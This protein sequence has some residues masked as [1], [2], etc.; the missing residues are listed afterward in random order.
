M[1]IEKTINFTSSPTIAIKNI[2]D[3]I[4]KLKTTGVSD[5]LVYPEIYDLRSY[6]NIINIKPTFIELSTAMKLKGRI[7]SVKGNLLVL[8]TKKDYV[9]INAKELVGY[10]IINS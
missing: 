10:E 3:A 1:G 2:C 7:V 5:Y 9:S 6:Y 8:K 4:N